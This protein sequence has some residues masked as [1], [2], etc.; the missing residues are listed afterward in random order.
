MYFSKGLLLCILICRQAATGGN[1]VRMIRMSDY[2]FKE[3]SI[4]DK[5][6]FSM[7]YGRMNGNWASSVSFLSMLAWK[8]SIR[9][10]HKVIGNYLCCLADD[11]TCS[12]WSLLPLLGH[13]DT[14]QINQCM[15]EVKAILDKLNIP[16]LFTDVSEWMLPYYKN[17]KS[18]KLEESYD[19]GLSDYIYKAEDFSKALDSQSNRYDYH[20]FINKFNPRLVLMGNEDDS[21]YLEFLKE[22]WCSSHECSYCTYGC[23]LESLRNILGIMEQAQAKGIT[24]YVDDKMAGY[25]IVTMEGN[26]LMYQF[27]KGIHSYRGINVYMH[28]S[29]YE[30]FGRQAQLINYTE[31]MN[32]PGLR[33]YK[34]RLAK[35]E[36]SHKY[37]LCTADK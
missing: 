16:V 36:L 30:L 27:K 25:T 31:D 1:K 29:C 28:R 11:T 5:E 37:E 10:Y 4:E 17:L 8:H 26:Q 2:G 18:V 6:L 33:L 14:D 34:Q 13:Y 35:Y 21:S 12:R 3:L 32:I 15:E 20:Y 19:Q 22:E 24:V 7:Y 9:I 23:L